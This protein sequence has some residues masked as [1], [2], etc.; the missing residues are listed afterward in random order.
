MKLR[1]FIMIICVFCLLLPAYGQK[2]NKKLTITGVV[3][4][5]N[6]R[7]VSG[8]MIFIDNQK[9]NVLTDEKGFYKIKVKPS[10][11]LISVFTLMNGM[12][13]AQIDGRTTI[14][15]NLKTA[16]TAPKTNAQNQSNNET[17]DMGYGTVKKKDLTKQVDKIDGTRNKYASYRNIY[18]MIRGEVAGV[19][20]NGNSITIQGP[21]SINGDNQPLFVVDGSTV[22]SLDGIS[23]SM[24][25]SIQVLK[26]AAAAIYGSSG[27]AGVILINLLGGGD[28][29]K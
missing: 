3:L 15:F 16:F 19:Q 23:P 27:S 6:Q 11:K 13:E 10:V 17:V 4:D 8:A 26:G 5:L 25:K 14:N 1:N 24:V 7:P 12:N 2:N 22:S 29:R 21:T 28:T 18:D 20:V 9:T